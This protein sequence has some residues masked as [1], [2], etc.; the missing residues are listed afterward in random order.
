MPDGQTTWKARVG[1]GLFR[2]ARSCFGNAAV[3]FSFAHMSAFIPV[4]RLFETE[5]VMAF[6]HPKPTH[7]IH[8]VIVPKTPVKSLM[9]LDQ[10]PQKLLFDIYIA[11]QSVVRELDLEKAGYSLV[12]NGGP[13]QDVEQ[14][15]FR[16]LAGR[17][18]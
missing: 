9:H 13:R 17:E 8:I 18:L 10:N 1:K 16:L 5:L 12:V 4:D 14:V 3:R 6:R 11:A 15:H 2:I 7:E